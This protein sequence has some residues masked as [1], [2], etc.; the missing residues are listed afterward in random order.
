MKVCIICKHPWRGDGMGHPGCLD[1][2]AVRPAWDTRLGGYAVIV[3]DGSI[4]LA[5]VRDVGW[6]LPG[7]GIEK[8]ESI[9]E[10]TIREVQEETGFD[11]TIG[12]LL[13]V[14]TNLIPAERRF[15]SPGVDL[16]AVQVAYACSV[17]GGALRNETD[18]STDEA[19]WFPLNELPE[20]RMAFVDW[21]IDLAMDTVR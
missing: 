13:G 4:L 8:S 11:A 16:K 14:R 3:N 2:D 7:G 12:A 19:R 9:E 6:S 21:A 17:V 18:N 1:G 10:G 20:D 5:H 15:R